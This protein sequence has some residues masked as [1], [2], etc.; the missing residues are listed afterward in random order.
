[1]DRQIR[2]V[3][4]P[5]QADQIDRIALEG[6]GADDVDAIV[7]DLEILGVR[8]AREAAAAAVRRSG[9]TPGAG[10][11]CRSSSAAQTIAVRSPTSLAT[12][13]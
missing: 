1:M 13:K 5:E 10:L 2:T 8:D 9:R 4:D 3:G 11:A 12:R 7:V 6:V